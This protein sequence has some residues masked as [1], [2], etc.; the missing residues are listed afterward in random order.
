MSIIV[1]SEV[2]LAAEALGKDPGSLSA[3]FEQSI[4]KGLTPEEAAQKEF[5][6]VFGVGAKRDAKGN[7]IESGKGSKAQQTS[8]HIAAL[9]KWEGRS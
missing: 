6:D 3:V 2:E 8:Q 4:N 5:E 7:P 9:A 1:K